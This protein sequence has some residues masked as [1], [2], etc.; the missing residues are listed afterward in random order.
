[1]HPGIISWKNLLVFSFHAFSTPLLFKTLF[2]PWERDRSAGPGLG[3][4][5]KI[6][7]A[8]LTRILGF[9]ARLALIFVGL[10]FTFLVFISFPFF[11]FIPIKID[12]ERLSR[13][14]SV[15]AFLSYGNTFHLN[16]H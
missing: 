7:F 3:L 14:G 5:E 13:L 1:M 10:L 11:F 12:P 9:I 15:G 2:S 6:V 16:A 8:I 4:L